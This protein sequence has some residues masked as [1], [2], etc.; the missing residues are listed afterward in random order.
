MIDA[1][2]PNVS[3]TPEQKAETSPKTHYGKYLLERQGRGILEMEHG[4]ATFE[5]PTKELVYIVDIYVEPEHRKSGLA[6]KMADEIV[7]AAKL[8]GCSQ[9]LG[10]VDPNANGAEDSIKVMFSYGFRL[11][12]VTESML[13]FVKDI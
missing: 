6:A 4:F 3:E 13:F 8:R 12:K 2:I 10:S 1:Q 11:G 5:F 7:K 9:L